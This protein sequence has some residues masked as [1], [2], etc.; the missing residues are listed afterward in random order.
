[1]GSHL[2]GSRGWKNF[3]DLSNQKFGRWTVLHRTKDN[4]HGQIM[5]R[6]KCDCGFLSD[7]KA[8]S[9][10]SGDSKS[11]GC[12]KNEL[13]SERMKKQ[14][15]EGL[16][17]SKRKNKKMICYKDNFTD[18]SGQRFHRWTVLKREQNDLCGKVVYSCKCDCGYIGNVNAGD[19]RRG[20]SKSC[21]CIKIEF[22]GELNRTGRNK[23]RK[24]NDRISESNTRKFE[25]VC[26]QD[27]GNLNSV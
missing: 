7:V 12:L 2:S 14:W 17:N 27:A 11:C 18:L 26:N 22:V 6:V 4:K 16:F 23:R 24:T 5:F 3:K 13:L 19:L 1:M 15:K 9:L 20:H 21:G 10:K 25:M 8:F